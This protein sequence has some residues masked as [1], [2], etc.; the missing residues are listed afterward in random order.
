MSKEKNKER[1][2]DAQESQEVSLSKKIK[3]KFSDLSAEILDNGWVILQIEN[4]ETISL[5]KYPNA[6]FEILEKMLEF[7]K[8]KGKMSKEKELKTLKDLESP[9]DSKEYGDSMFRNR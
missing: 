1:H 6:R 8:S 4:E 5:G 3:S 2:A 9:I 7:V